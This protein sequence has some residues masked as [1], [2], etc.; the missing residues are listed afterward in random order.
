MNISTVDL[1]SFLAVAESGHLTESAAE[2]GVPQP[3]LSRRIARLEDELGATLFDRVG[4]SLQLN[5]R[6]RAFQ[7]YARDMVAAAD[8]GAREIARLMNPESG[9]VRIGFMHSLGTW[10][11]PSLLREYRNRYPHVQFE[12]R[13]GPARELEE[14]VLND[15]IDLAFV[16]PA[17][18]SPDL[19]WAVMHMQPLVL[20]VPEGHPLADRKEV[21]LEEA[22]QESFIGMKPDYG[23]Q[24]ILDRLAAG[25]GFEPKIAFRTEE[26]TTVSGLVASGLGVALLPVGDVEGVSFVPLAPPYEREIGMVWRSGL[27]EAPPVELFRRFVLYGA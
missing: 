4:R 12:L 2:L 3:T 9:T 1:R 10:L 17:P 19:S 25:A 6:G 5:A 22:A 8:A 18:S 21:A 26:M 13:Q 23:I 7:T 15:D 27:A 16:S 14:A 11:I 20:A 24:I